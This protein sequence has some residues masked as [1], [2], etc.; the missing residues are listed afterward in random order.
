MTAP[1]VRWT[2]VVGGALLLAIVV[3][4]WTGAGDAEYSD[5]LD[6]GNPGENG[7]QAVAQVL[8]DQ[9]VA[10]TVARSAEELAAAE[11]DADTTVFVT[12]TEQLARSTIKQLRQEAEPALLVLAD[13]PPYVI[14][15]IDRV[16][17][18]PARGGTSD[19]AASCSELGLAPDLELDADRATAYIAD[20]CFPTS[21]GD[22][23][24]TGPSGAVYLGARR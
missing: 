13:P 3:A 1:R 5:P 17:S 6:P 15:R 4:V 24:V 2:L 9:G 10:V 18:L 7:M 8:A 23:L 16:G 11:V 12:G 19:V 21:A 14:D 22:L 20:G